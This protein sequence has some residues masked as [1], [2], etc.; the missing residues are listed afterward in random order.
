MGQLAQPAGQKAAS[1]RQ[2]DRL[3][4]LERA[5]IEKTASCAALHE[6]R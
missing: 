2:R 1:V 3:G 6:C 4:P 5:S